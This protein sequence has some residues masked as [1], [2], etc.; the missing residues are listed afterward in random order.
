MAAANTCSPESDQVSIEELD[1]WDIDSL[2]DF[3][4]R[5]G[6]KVTGTRRE[7]TSRVYFLY[8]KGIPEEPTAKETE[9]SNNEDYQAI[10]SAKLPDPHPLKLKRWNGEQAEIQKRPPV[11]F[12]GNHW[13]LR[14]NGST[15]LTRESLTAYKEEKA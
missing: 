1:N 13:F 10:I 6:Y 9:A 8:N 12:I 7:L 4:L 5:R 14:S 15:G 3:C 11:R 2:K